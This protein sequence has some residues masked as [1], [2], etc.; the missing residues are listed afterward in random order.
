MELGATVCTLN[1]VCCECPLS[2][3]CRV[4]NGIYIYIYIYIYM[5]VCVCVCVCIYSKF[6]YLC[7]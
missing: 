4:Y 6:L 1:P 5:C 2:R 7:L 3:E